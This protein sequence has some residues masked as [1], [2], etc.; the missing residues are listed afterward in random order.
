MLPPVPTDA[1]RKV[2]WPASSRV[3]ASVGTGGN[4]RL[5][6]TALGAG[7][8]DQSHYV[9]QSAAYTFGTNHSLAVV[10]DAAG[11][12]LDLTVTLAPV[13][14]PAAALALAAAALGLAAVRR[15][16]AD[17]ESPTAAVAE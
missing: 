17:R 8:I 7:V 2:Y 16:R 3:V 15:R 13:P 9:L 6:G 1:R 5:N 11:K 12:H 14:E 4:I 10:T